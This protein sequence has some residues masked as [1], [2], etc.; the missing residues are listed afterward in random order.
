MRRLC[1]ITAAPQ[2]TSPLLSPALLLSSAKALELQ[3]FRGVQDEEKNA[4]PSS[5]DAAAPVLSHP[6]LAQPG[7]AD[8]R[9]GAAHGG[10]GDRRARAPHQRLRQAGGH[11]R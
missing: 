2:A 3:G 5:A 1:G 4:K 6:A 10:A 11:L 8:V 9:P 7:D